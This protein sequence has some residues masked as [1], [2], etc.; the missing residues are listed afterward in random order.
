MQLEHEFRIRARLL[1]AALMIFSLALFASLAARAVNETG[2]TNSYAQVAQSFINGKPYVERCFDRDCAIR[3]GK[4]YVVFPPLPGVIAAPLVALN[5]VG[6]K[7]FIPLAI[8]AMIV[9]VLIWH[10]ILAKL[11]LSHDSRMGLLAAIAFASPLFY[12]TLKADGIWFFAQAMAFPLV[13]LAIHEAISERLFSAGLALAAA[14]LCRQMS[15]FYTPILFMLALRPEMPLLTIDRD[16]LARAFRLGVPLLAGLASYLAYNVWRFG[17]PL[18]TGYSSINF[19]PGFIQERVNGHGVWSP[20]Y[21]VFNVFYLLIQGF[22][23]D[24]AEP[25]R[26]TLTGLDNAGTSVLSASPWLILLFFTPLRRELI[27]CVLLI[28]GMSAALLFYHSN[29]FSQYNVQRYVLDWLP[30]ALLM[31]AAALRSLEN[32]IL[33]RLLIL[34]GMALNL[35]TVAVLAV[36]HSA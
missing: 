16:R 19:P 8:V 34:W 6:T 12:V 33:L 5:G 3:D 1:S 10:Q 13:S 2:S 20:A 32:Q 22:H 9:S 15:I 30:A 31:L 29:G 28:A 25:Q 27:A 4:T 17:N 18:D 14:L 23:A 26:V 24:F 7:G 36:T 35:V 11:A 21:F